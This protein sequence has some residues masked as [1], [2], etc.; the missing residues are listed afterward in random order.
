[1]RRDFQ[2]I[3]PE[4]AGIPSAAVAAFIDRLEDKTLPMHRADFL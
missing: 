2:T 3:T 1:M 4:A